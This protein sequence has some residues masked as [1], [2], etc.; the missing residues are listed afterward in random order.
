M[1]IEVTSS[2]G[3]DICKKILDSLLK[4]SLDMGIGGL[5]GDGSE[6]GA[7]DTGADAGGGEG[8]AGERKFQLTV[9]QVKVVDQEG[10]LKVVYPSRTDFMVEGVHVIRN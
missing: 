1:L 2:T 3:L 8:Q 10:S 9:E 4:E 7:T 6:F 5:V